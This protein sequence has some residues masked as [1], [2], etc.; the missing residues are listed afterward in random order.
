MRA[1]LPAGHACPRWLQMWPKTLLFLR[2]HG[3]D[4]GPGGG[5]CAELPLHASGAESWNMRIGKDFE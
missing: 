4:S 5:G 1:S 2:K 3:R